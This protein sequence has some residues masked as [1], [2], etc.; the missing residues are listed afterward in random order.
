MSKQPSQPPTD[1]WL[2]FSCAL[3]SLLLLFG[4]LSPCL[5]IGEFALGLRLR[6]PRD[7]GVRSCLF[8][9]F[10]RSSDVLLCLLKI[11]LRIGELALGR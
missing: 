7:P 3:T 6:L 10:V 11:R 9:F 4:R 2:A 5:R 8:R 1:T